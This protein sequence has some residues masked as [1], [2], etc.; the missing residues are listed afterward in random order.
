MDADYWAV[1][2]MLIATG[3]FCQPTRDQQYLLFGDCGDNKMPL[4]KLALYEPNTLHVLFCTYCL[5]KQGPLSSF[6]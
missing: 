5:Y 3:T 6:C 4:F 1:G 2:F